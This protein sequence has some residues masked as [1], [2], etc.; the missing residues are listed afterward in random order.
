M[1]MPVDQRSLT[2]E[3]TADLCAT[4]I[5][6]RGTL[7]VFVEHMPALDPAAFLAQ[8]GR[9]VER[10]VRVAVLGLSKPP[11]KAPPKIELTTDPTEANQW[12]NDLAAREGTPFVT[13]VLG[14]A[15][16]LNSLRSAVPLLGP[17]DLRAEAVKRAMALL[18]N[19]ERDAFWKA[20]GK[21]PDLFA[22]DSI[23][24]LLSEL[25]G[26]GRTQAVLM[27]VEP[28]E[29]WRLGL[30]QDESLF[31]SKGPR[32][33][34][35]A[36]RRSL[37]LVDRLRSLG[38]RDRA[39]IVSVIEKGANE[40]LKACARA[41]LEF[42][43]TANRERLGKLD[44]ESVAQVLKGVENEKPTGA[45]GTKRQRLEGD[46]L[47]VE[48]LIEEGGR[49][50]KAAAKRFK[51][52]LDP[53]PDGEIEPEEINVG[54]RRVLPRLKTGT[55]QMST[56]FPRA[57]SEDMWGGIVS[58]PGAKDYVSAL[59]LLASDEAEV[60]PFR[61]GSPDNVRTMLERAVGQGWVERDVLQKWDRYAVARAAVLPSQSQL[62]DHPLM[63]LA[64][65]DNLA[66]RVDKLLSSYEDALAAI[67]QTADVLK[68]RG[69][70]DPAK[71]L[72]ARAL[73][74][75]LLFVR[76]ANDTVAIGAPTHP[77]HLWRWATLA[78]LLQE[79]SKELKDLGGDI[80]RDL[81]SEPPPVSPSVLLTPFVTEAGISRSQPFVCVG[82]FG[83]L[84]LFTEPSARNLG[85]FRARPLAKIAQRFL[86]LMPHAAFGFRVALVDPLTIAGTLEE[87][88]EMDSPFGDDRP[89]AIH[90]TVFRTR[91]SVD[92]TD[93]EDEDLEDISRNI[94][95][96]GGS[97]S[98]VVGTKTAQQ[99]ADELV[100]S[101]AHLTVVFQPGNGTPLRIGI[102][103]PPTLSPLVVPRA[104]KYDEFDDRLDVIVA[105]EGAPFHTYHALF[106]EAFDMPTSDFV[107]RRSGASTWSKELN[108][109]AK[110]SVWCTV[111]DQALEPTLNLENAM[112]LD[113]R[114]DAGRDIV[115]FTAKPDTIRELVVEAVRQAGLIP[116]EATVT[117]TFDQVQ[118]LSGEALLALA[119]MSD[120]ILIEPRVAKGTLGVIAAARWY[121][122]TYPDA[123]M[124]SLDDALSRRWV[125]GHA[126]NDNRHG[127][128]VAV[129]L[130]NEGVVVDA[131]EVK[132]YQDDAAGLT[133]KGSAVEGK[134]AIQ[135]DQT[136]KI[137]RKL[138]T[139]PSGKLSQLDR[140]RQDILRDHL[141]RAVAS[142]PYT[143]DRRGRLVTLLTELF[144]A[145][146]STIAGLIFR[147]TI[148]S[149]TAE[150]FPISPKRFKTPADNQLGIVD[151][152]ESEAA[153]PVSEGGNSGSGPGSAGGG[154]AAKNKARNPGPRITDKPP[155][156]EPEPEDS[157]ED[158]G[159]RSVGKSKARK[160]QPGSPPPVNKEKSAGK[161][162]DPRVLI[163]E[164][165]SGETI[166]WEPH[167]PDAP[168]NNFGILVTGDSGA[169]KTQV[170]R[171]IIH[172]V[173]D[174][175]YP[176]CIFDFKNDYADPTFGKP[177][178]LR[179]YDVS[180]GGVPFNPLSLIPDEHGE[181][182]PI[183]QI[184]TLTDI[185]R[186]IFGL[187]E[188]QQARLKKAII[189]AYEADGVD[190]KTRYRVADVKVVPGFDDVVKQLEDDEKNEPLL[191]RL[192]PLFDLGLFPSSEV[193][194][195]TFEALIDDRVVL[196]LHSLP[197]DRIKAAVAEFMIVRLHGYVLRGDQPRELRRVLV[198]D[199]AWRVKDSERLQE[200]AREGRA[201]G[202]GIA[203]G[204]QFPGDIRE[205]LA[206]NLA[207]QIFLHNK[208]A[209]HQK[210]IARALVGTPSG[211]KATHIIQTV[212]RLQKHEGFVRN[213]QHSPY[214]LV[215]TTPHHERKHK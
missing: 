172:D 129:R 72:L 121:E 141:Y 142:R 113:W 63:A 14:S 214:V 73:V 132:A 10:Q 106:C 66:A 45:P 98:V 26:K 28:T 157:E 203:I 174:L 25:S 165:S 61:P 31:S 212:A 30:L 75:D 12:R 155:E 50:V 135:V 86:R 196:D 49:G 89:V 204:T 100:A 109:L 35:A 122:R 81:V 47:A 156:P 88:A 213:Q 201:F 99:V 58:A 11:G 18:P 160:P 120:G 158:S 37:D 199:E 53:D 139:T 44:V 145:G 57:L 176:I 140:A 128:L 164:S 126:D 54:T 46:V 34:S 15:P 188:Q 183:T 184:H 112:R 62:S 110:G 148:E 67:K 105:G 60:A 82:S 211:P 23:L 92:A 5:G 215:R 19:P 133:I 179:V 173:A 180:R 42:E 83:A 153:G 102:T 209:D 181:S 69:S 143:R 163:G 168:L 175:G 21:R 161:R 111:V 43:T 115:T 205:N 107:G 124:I 77:F 130:G 78:K 191:N 136:I 9:K 162:A 87:L 91:P 108:E 167:R 65:D 166:Y 36:I 151:I 95:D 101:P 118:R 192:S 24:A 152:V 79:R 33:A 68:Q 70:F 200:L 1:G 6:K 74:L 154:K 17:E 146:A 8:L 170:L 103:A 13:L 56:A 104:Y 2:A 190:P 194:T 40:T 119:R 131:V 97:I 206:G 169:G 29:V 134:A 7:G 202:I 208:E 197:D 178:G 52:E 76:T 80:L 85:K 71:R 123:L 189:H 93:E 127:D 182:Q 59:K 193:V 177:V 150:V 117:R 90:A 207:T 185:F 51:N 55:R 149:K 20:V 48:L 84:P 114:S 144:E 187:G 198:F 125:L 138:L 186:R 4:R 137:L 64:G 210:A 159:A 16:K 94:H 27:E 96:W 39:N 41:M 116:N 22:L 195:T 147:V 171:A 38:R 32:G 3:M